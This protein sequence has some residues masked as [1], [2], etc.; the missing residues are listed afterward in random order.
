M[1]KEKHLEMLAC[2]VVVK[3][4]FCDTRLMSGS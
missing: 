4:E 3:W 2:K 1:K